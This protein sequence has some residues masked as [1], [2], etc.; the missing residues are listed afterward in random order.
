VSGSS[1][2]SAIN[3]TG[4]KLLL[5]RKNSNDLS[6]KTQKNCAFTY[7]QR[8][9]VNWSWKSFANFV[10]CHLR[11]CKELNK[12]RS[13]TCVW[14]S[15][16]SSHQKQLALKIDASGEDT[17]RRSNM[18]IIVDKHI[19]NE[20]IHHHYS[21]KRNSWRLL[22]RLKDEDDEKIFKFPERKHKKSAY[23]SFSILWNDLQMWWNSNFVS[24]KTLSTHAWDSKDRWIPDEFHEIKHIKALNAKWFDKKLRINFL[25]WAA[26]DLFWLRS[27]LI[28]R[29]GAARDQLYN[30]GHYMGTILCCFD[31][32]SICF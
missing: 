12:T 2:L 18:A 27:N 23:Q 30:F 8:L 11:A 1:L 15:C 10:C 21:V 29:S 7:R 19:F 31:S 13:L 26:F 4:S 16:F 5:S 3:K 25:F 14:F 6:E 32:F 24:S 28:G 22:I 20:N 9:R 17:Q